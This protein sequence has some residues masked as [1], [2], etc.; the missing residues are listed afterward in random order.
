[1]K[2]K[3]VSKFWQTLLFC[4]I[5]AL[6]NWTPVGRFLQSSFLLNAVLGII[7][8]LWIIA[9][10]VTWSDIKEKLGKYKK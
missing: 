7:V 3:R 2:K 10:M 9:I 5:V 4:G 1:M 6:F 8:F